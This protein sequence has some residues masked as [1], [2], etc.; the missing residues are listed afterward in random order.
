M[1]PESNLKCPTC[2]YVER[3][4]PVNY[5]QFF[6][7]CKSCHEIMKAK[8]GHCCV[9]CSYGDVSCPS[10]TKSKLNGYRN[11]GIVSG[12]PL[13]LAGSGKPAPAGAYGASFAPS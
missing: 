8:E 7:E 3:V 10:G 2:G 5:C 1:Q 6:Y 12:E 13:R 11:Y 4:M 9:F